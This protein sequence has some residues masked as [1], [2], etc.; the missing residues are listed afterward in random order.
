VTANGLIATITPDPAAAPGD[1]TFTYIVS[2]SGSPSLSAS[3]TIKV[4]ISALSTNQPPTA[5]AATTV[6]TRGV[7]VAVTVVASDPEDGTALTLTV[8]TVPVGWTRTISGLQVT[9]T[10]SSTATGTSVLNYTVTDSGGATANS[11]ITVNVCTVSIASIGS[12]VQ[13]HTNGQNVGK[14]KQ[15]VPVAITTNGACGGALVL[16]F[17]PKTADAQETTIAFGT[18]TSVTIDK[19]AYTWD[20]VDR[21]VTL[22]VR[23]GANGIVEATGT[24]QVTT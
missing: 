14:L 13:V 4:T 5:Q 18:A 10:P 19:S 3:N 21:S 12:P 15:D 6:A 8:P 24:L 9:I 17:K 1:Y 20:T 23:Q 16:A 22:N 2:D 11:T 7:P